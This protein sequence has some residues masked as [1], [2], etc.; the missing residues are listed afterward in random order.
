MS[1]SAFKRS[2]I[3]IVSV[4]QYGAQGNNTTDDT[5][6]IQ[7]AI[8][9]LIAAGGGLL[10]FPSGTYKVS[11]ALTTTVPIYLLGAGLKNT[12]VRQTS[13]TA[14]GVVFD[15]PSL[16][17]GGGIDSISIE[18]GAGWVTAS[19]QGSGS[20]GIGLQVKAS[21]GLFIGENFGVHN[22]DTG[23]S[24][25]GSYYAQFTK[26]QVLYATTDAI[27]LSK[28]GAT[29]G[30]GNLFRHGKIS[31]FGFTGTNTASYGIRNN[32][33]GGD[34]F[35]FLD[36]TTFNKG[37]SL[38]A[39]ATENVLYCFFTSV[40]ADTCLTNNW[41]F[42]GT[43][44][45]VW[46]TNLTNCWG[47][48]S[49]NGAGVVVK[50]ANIDSIKWIGGA[51]RENGTHGV[52]L[53]YGKNVAFTGTEISSNS[54]LT[55]NTYNG[56]QVDA[57]VSDWSF[58]GCEVGNFASTLTGQLNNVNIAAGAS[59]NFRIIGCGL[60]AP[61]AGG[62]PIA[63]GSSASS[64][65][66]QNNTPLQ[67]A[68]VNQTRGANLTGVSLGTVAAGATVYMGGNGAQAV[69]DDS[70][71]ML[72][73]SGIVSQL[74]VEVVAAPGAGETFTYTVRKN[75]SD[76]AMTGTISGGA[77]FQVIVTTNAFTVAATDKLTLKLVTSGG[78]VVTRHRWVMTV[79]P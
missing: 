16:V 66:V 24:C 73:R 49:T 20:T 7:T 50:G 22:F 31:N 78:A 63:N 26:F 8:N 3:D 4:K 36:V 65:I 39:T 64:Y 27:L 55:A 70:S 71:M 60:E 42:D 58:L 30:A 76:T 51:I 23:I 68:G 19:N 41:E 37:I 52:H 67:S 47:S 77:S 34:F 10:Y 28:N 17:Q 46:A 53:Q 40:L 61:G 11:A 54:K 33:S 56:V 1:S 59:T 35:E 74:V 21:N 45:K 9:A 32:A 75:G 48:Y 79:D 5:T 12:V 43:S 44:G 38:Q 6:S 69:E 13:P 15:Y 57:G 25:L 14:N 2:V 62:V 18:A 72:G 29:V